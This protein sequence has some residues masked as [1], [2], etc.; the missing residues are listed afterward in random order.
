MAKRIAEL[1]REPDT[2]KER[3][4]RSGADEQGNDPG[5]K[6]GTAELERS[7]GSEGSPS[8]NGSAKVR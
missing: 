1:K 6:R 4:A 3:I 7:S 2:V 8:S 5:K